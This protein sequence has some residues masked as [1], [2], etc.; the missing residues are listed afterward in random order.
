MGYTKDQRIM[1]A[2]PDKSAYELLGLGLSEEKYN[3]LVKANYQPQAKE[4]I[5]PDVIT[6]TVTPPPQPV[7]PVVRQSAQPKL[8]R[9]PQQPRRPGTKRAYLHNKK[10]GKKTAMTLASAQFAARLD[11]GNYNVIPIN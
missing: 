5:V 9:A 8:S 6:P 11:K 1:N 10:T 7:Q 3:E 2:N 4:K